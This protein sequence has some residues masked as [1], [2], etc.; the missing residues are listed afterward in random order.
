MRAVTEAR[1]SNVSRQ[2]NVSESI[3]QPDAAAWASPHAAVLAWPHAAVLARRDADV[4]RAP[5]GAPGASDSV[6]PTAVTTFLLDPAAATGHRFRRSGQPQ[7]P[8]KF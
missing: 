2:M 6:T 4:H 1:G 7:T 3:P 8:T 5:G